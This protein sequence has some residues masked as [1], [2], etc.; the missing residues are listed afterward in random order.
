MQTEAELRLADEYRKRVILA[1]IYARLGQAAEARDHIRRALALNPG[2]PWTLFLAGEMEGLLGN[3]QAALSYVRQAVD[4]DWLQLPYF[5]HYQRSDHG[6]Y[7][8]RN[9]PR[10]R[11]LRSEVARR[12]E[13]LRKSL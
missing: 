11:A 7:A 2:H 4:R 10:F 1:L 3:R 6:F 13:E 5:D 9:D 12:V 8:I